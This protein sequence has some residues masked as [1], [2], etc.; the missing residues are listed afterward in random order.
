MIVVQWAYMAIMRT[1][2]KIGEIWR[3]RE[4]KKIIKILKIKFT[5]FEGWD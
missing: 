1:I 4:R 2:Y 3:E 5:R